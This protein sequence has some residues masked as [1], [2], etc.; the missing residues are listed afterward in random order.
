M[1][2]EEE[3]VNENSETK[4]QKLYVSCQLQQQYK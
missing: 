1:R 2:R 4:A 3:G